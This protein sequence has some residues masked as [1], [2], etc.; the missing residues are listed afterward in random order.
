MPTTNLISNVGFGEGATHTVSP[1]SKLANLAALPLELPLRHPAVVEARLDADR[2]TSA[3]VFGVN[4]R[5]GL[6][7]TVSSELRRS[8]R[9]AKVA[10]TALI[11]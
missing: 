1:E 3:Q 2:W 6:I 4:E 9:R 11:P 7:T 5:Q 8:L 10:L